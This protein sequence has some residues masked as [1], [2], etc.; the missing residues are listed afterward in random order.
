MSVIFF[1]TGNFRFSGNPSYPPNNYDMY[2]G[3]LAEEEQFERAVSNSLRE[4][5]KAK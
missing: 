5:G 2:T 1:C 3:G 4:R